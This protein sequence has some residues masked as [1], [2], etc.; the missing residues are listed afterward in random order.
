MK[1]VGNLLVLCGVVLLLA[2]IFGF[3]IINVSGYSA[4]FVDTSIGLSNSFGTI[5]YMSSRDVFLLRIMQYRITMTLVGS[6]VIV[7]GLVLKVHNQK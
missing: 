1:A 3:F 7:L 4:D 2:G 6:L 5:Q